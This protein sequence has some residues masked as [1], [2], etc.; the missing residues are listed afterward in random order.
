[1]CNQCKM[2]GNGLEK[3]KKTPELQAGCLKNYA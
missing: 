1:M 3:A 2:E